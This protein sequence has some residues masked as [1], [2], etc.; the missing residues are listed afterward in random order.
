MRYF[1]IVLFEA[2]SKKA[3]QKK[4]K[5]MCQDA[6]YL[7]YD[8]RKDTSGI[9]QLGD[10]LENKIYLIDEFLKNEPANDGQISS[11]TLKKLPNNLFDIPGIRQCLKIGSADESGHFGLLVKRK[12]LEKEPLFYGDD[13]PWDDFWPEDY[14]ADL[15]SD[16]VEYAFNGSKKSMRSSKRVFDLMM[17]RTNMQVAFMNAEGRLSVSQLN[18]RPPEVFRTPVRNVGAEHVAAFA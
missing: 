16:A 13:E 17:D 3:S 7:V 14:F 12:K 1:G 15:I 18:V 5:D 11:S 8:N 9:K 4:L 6:L 10:Y 2:P